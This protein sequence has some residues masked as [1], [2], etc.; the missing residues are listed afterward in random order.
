MNPHPQT[1]CQDT[2]GEDPLAD[3]RILKKALVERAGTVWSRQDRSPSFAR[4]FHEALA[5]D[6]GMRKETG[7]VIREWL[8]AFDEK[9]LAE[10]VKWIDE[11]S[12]SG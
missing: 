10:Q 3:T 5:I 9:R 11:I 2:A 12:K 4:G 8:N 1:S 6:S 7:R